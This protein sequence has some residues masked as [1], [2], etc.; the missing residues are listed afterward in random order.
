MNETGHNG[1]NSK[2]QRP[3]LNQYPMPET[4]MTKTMVRR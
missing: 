2:L 3:N 4:A 1:G